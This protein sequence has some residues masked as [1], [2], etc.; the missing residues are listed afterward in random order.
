[1]SYYLGLMAQWIEKLWLECKANV[2]QS[3][4][5]SFLGFVKWCLPVMC[6]EKK[7]SSVCD[8]M[9]SKSTEGQESDLEKFLKFCVKNLCFLIPSNFPI[10]GFIFETMVQMND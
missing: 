10:F 1:M 5:I 8:K 3:L 9:L 7:I 4:G 6:L 2:N